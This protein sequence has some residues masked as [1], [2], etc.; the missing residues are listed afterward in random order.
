MVN[1]TIITVT[2]NNESSIKKYLESLTRNLPENSEVILI[3]NASIDKTVS[4]INEFY[5]KRIK[6]FIQSENLG[7]AKASNLAAKSAQGEYLLFLNSDMEV[8]D[9]AIK[10]LLEVKLNDPIIGL[11]V[12]KLILPNGQVQKS[13]KLLPTLKGALAEY[14]G[15][16]KNSYQE[17]APPDDKLCQV[18]CAYGAAMLIEKSF[19]NK[20]GGFDERYFLYYEDIDLC[21]R[22]KK[23]QKKIIY[24]P[25]AVLKHLVGGSTTAPNKNSNN[26]ITNVISLFI[27]LRKGTRDYYQVQ[28]RNIYHGIF[29]SFLIAF[30]IFISSKLKLKNA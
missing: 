15:N 22:I 28:G 29:I 6:L 5:D 8:L 25:N 20:L 9:G 1:L 16:M 21:R 3:D 19:F 4:I 7:F 18:E 27:P 30:I 11:V 23:L 12:P 26:T 14:I 2:Y 24:T 17:Y 10:K 13:V